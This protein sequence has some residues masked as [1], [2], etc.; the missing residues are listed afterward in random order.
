MITDALNIAAHALLIAIAISCG[1][2]L[3]FAAGF[4]IQEFSEHCEPPCRLRWWASRL[5]IILAIITIG[6]L[7]FGF[8]ASWPVPAWFKPQAAEST[9]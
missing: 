5:A 7:C 1:V 9:K 6:S 8:A 3:F 4:A 2:G